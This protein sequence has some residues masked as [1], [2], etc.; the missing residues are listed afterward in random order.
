MTVFIDTAVLMYAGGRDHPLCEP[1]RD[2]LRQVEA[3]RLD[4]VISA[5]VVQEI[6]H[7]FVAMRRTELGAE[8]ARDALDLFAPV[9]AIT[10]AVVQ[11]MPGLA[12]RY[13][14]LAARD[15]VHV[16]TCAEEGVGAIVSPD[17]AFDRVEGLARFA[18]GDTA[19]LSA[20]LH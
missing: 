11:R 14:D 3:G 7:R 20:H 19:A 2:L 9:L 12:A 13:P 5:E 16:A 17:R 4:A 18:P 8:M 6:F 15:L 1:C 10:H